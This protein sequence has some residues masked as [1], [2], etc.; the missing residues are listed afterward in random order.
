[1][2][3]WRGEAALIEQLHDPA[4]LLGDDA[5]R[6]PHPVDHDRDEDQDPE[7]RPDDQP[8]GVGRRVVRRGAGPAGRAAEHVE[9]RDVEARSIG[10][11]ACE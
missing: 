3:S 7:H 5:G 8:A 11:L 1:M 6:D 10:L 4:R 9:A 2:T